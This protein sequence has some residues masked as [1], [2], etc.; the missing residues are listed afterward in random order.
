MLENSFSYYNRNDKENPF[1]EKTNEH[2]F[3]IAE[4]FYDDT[5]KLEFENFLIQDAKRLTDELNGKG[6]AIAKKF[7]S[8]TMEKRALS[9]FVKLL[10]QKWKPY[11]D[12]EKILLEY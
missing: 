3:W 1:P 12:Y 4:R 8:Y 11:D 7:L 10:L 9:L 6:D 5:V 2:L